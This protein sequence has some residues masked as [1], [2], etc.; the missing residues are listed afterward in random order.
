MRGKNRDP[1]RRGVQNE[2]TW[3][4]LCVIG[5]RN[6][7]NDILAFGRFERGAGARFFFFAKQFFLFSPKS[8]SRTKQNGFVILAWEEKERCN[9]G[10]TIPE[11]Y[12]RGLMICE[13]TSQSRQQG[14]S[15]FIFLFVRRKTDDLV[16]F[17]ISVWIYFNFLTFSFCISSFLLTN[18]VLPWSN[19][20]QTFSLSFFYALE[21][22]YFLKITIKRKQI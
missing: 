16:Y 6:G 19:L 7:K 3:R 18:F 17:G 8:F 1:F 10:R 12:Q 15:F 11:F 5:H 2:L 9:V 20:I 21:F 14:L 22:T 4:L 13:G